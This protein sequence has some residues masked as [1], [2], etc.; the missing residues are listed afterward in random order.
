MMLIKN[1]TPIFFIKK[2]S[3]SKSWAHKTLMQILTEILHVNSVF[4][5]MESSHVLLQNLKNVKNK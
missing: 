2:V 5:M 4:K 1:T 3:E